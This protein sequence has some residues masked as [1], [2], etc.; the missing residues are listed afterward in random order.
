[1]K[2]LKNTQFILSVIMMFYLSACQ[3]IAKK[4]SVFG[5]EP[6]THPMIANSEVARTLT[7]SGDVIGYVHRGIFNY[8]GI[9][10]A[11][12]ERFMPPQKPDKWED[13][14]SCRS[15][16]PVCPINIESM[17]LFDEMEFAQQHNFWYM[18]EDACQNLNVWSPAISDGKK[19]PV[20]VW[21]HG[22]GYTA[23]SSCELPSYD[24]ENLSQ[25]GDVVVVSIN[26]RLNVLG[27]LDLSAV[28]GKYAQSANVGM[29]DVV[30]ALEWVH[31]NIAN[32]GGDP[33]N[34]T[35]FGQS[36]GDGK[37]V[38]LLY[39]PSAKGLFHKA[40]IQSG[41]VGRFSSKEATQKVGLAIMDELGL[42]KNEVDKLRDVPYDELLAAGNRAFAKAGQGLGRLGWAPS[43]DGEFIPLQPGDP[44]AEE[45]AK[46]I[47]LIAGSN[48][49]EFGSFGG[50]T[51]LL[52]ADEATIIDYL[53]G[54][55]GDKTDA[56]VAA[57]KEAYP[58]TRMPSDM[59]DVDLMFRPMLLDFIKLKSSVPGGA[60]VYNYVFEWNAPHLDGMLKSSHCMEIAFVF[61][62]IARTEEYNGG[63]PEAY[64]LANKLSKTWA[65]FAWTGNPNNEAMPEWEPF[66]P[67]GGA[68]MLFDNHSRLVH[69][70]DKKLMEIAAP[71]GQ[72]S[73]F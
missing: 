73:L 48:Q 9:P 34:V 35:I 61:N 2:F 63:T 18:K 8:K 31:N 54:R 7:E 24:G 55:Y 51:E 1:M 72:A 41:A 66:T 15:Y 71:V 33:G 39:S 47:P 65:T 11:K 4:A 21:L 22:G 62:N 69:N 64:A 40:I 17:I 49:V 12:S 59:K 50:G 29:M 25:T 3:S 5:E 56:Y 42:K 32:F 43:C 13:V 53:N 36:E 45:L 44:G 23:G 37:V 52:H 10:Y 67:D 28:D 14:R 26:H 38:T 16:G 57:F 46:D 58:S 68:T 27:F 19:R 6:G 70:H 30:A 60:P 20:M